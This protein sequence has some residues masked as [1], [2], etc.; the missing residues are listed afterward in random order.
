M[1]LIICARS[2]SISVAC[3]SSYSCIGCPQGTAYIYNRKPHF[4]NVIQGEDSGKWQF[5]TGAVFYRTN[6]P[7]LACTRELLQVKY[8]LKRT[9]LPFI[10]IL[11]RCYQLNKLCMWQLLIVSHI[12]SHRLHTLFHTVSCVLYDC[13]IAEE[14]C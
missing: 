3:C 9:S 14:I 1:L 12:V 7:Q 8:S 5:S 6:K 13:F 10:K 2:S 11:C 4:Y